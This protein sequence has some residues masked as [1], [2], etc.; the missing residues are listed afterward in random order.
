M[1]AVNGMT[2][3]LLKQKWV[4]SENAARTGDLTECS[5]VLL[6]QHMKY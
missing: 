6:G 5:L 3:V 1:K 4:H 2:K